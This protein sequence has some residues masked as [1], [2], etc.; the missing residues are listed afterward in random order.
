[1]TLPLPVLIRPIEFGQ[2][3]TPTD[4]LPGTLPTDTLPTDTPA[5]ATPSI[6]TL[7]HTVADPVD[8]V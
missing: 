1:M 8:L 6:T 7:Q 2:P 3:D 4:A 5:T